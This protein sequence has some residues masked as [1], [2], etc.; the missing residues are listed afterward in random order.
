MCHNGYK[1][2]RLGNDRLNSI[3]NAQVGEALIYVYLLCIKIIM[4][5]IIFSS[6]KT[7]AYQ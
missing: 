3:V 4:F 7:R 1:Q 2:N 5:F 6:F